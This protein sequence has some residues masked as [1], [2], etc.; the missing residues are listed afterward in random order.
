MQMIRAVGR[1]PNG[2]KIVIL[3][4]SRENCARLLDD[5]PIP[6]DFSQFGLDCE[7][8][9][10]GGETEEAIMRELEKHVDFPPQSEWRRT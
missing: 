10:C 6:L 1:R 2:K 4:L 9:L 7:V 3:G 5:Q 8:L